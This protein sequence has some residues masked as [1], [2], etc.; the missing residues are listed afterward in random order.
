MA[1][2]KKHCML[3]LFICVLLSI[4]S[5]ATHVY[6]EP[7]RLLSRIKARNVAYPEYGVE[8]GSGWNS[9]LGQKMPSNCVDVMEVSIPKSEF[10][11]DYDFVLDNYSFSKKSAFSGGGKFKGFGF[12]ASVS[13]SGSRESRVNRDFMSVMFTAQFNFGSTQAVPVL[14]PKTILGDAPRRRSEA[15]REAIRYGRAIRL[16]EE[17]RVLLEGQ[18]GLSKFIQTCGDAF[19]IAVHRGV[20]ANVLATLQASTQAAKEEFAASVSA[21]G[22]GGAVGFTASTQ[23][24]SS[25]ENKTVSYQFFQ[26][27]GLEPFFDVSKPEAL[28]PDALGS[29]FNTGRLLEGES[30]FMATVLPYANLLDF[31]GN[32]EAAKVLTIFDRLDEQRALFAFLSDLAAII[33]EIDRAQITGQESEQWLY[34]PVSIQ[35]LE[36]ERDVALTRFQIY[37]LMRVLSAS[38]E[39]CYIDQALCD[40]DTIEVPK[41]ERESLSAQLKYSAAVLAKERD[42]ANARISALVEA[43][44]VQTG[45]S[46]ENLLQRIVTWVDSGDSV[47]DF[48]RGNADDLTLAIDMNGL[49]EGLVSIAAAI[50]NKSMGG[51]SLSPSGSGLVFERPLDPMEGDLIDDLV[52]R[53]GLQQFPDYES[54]IREKLADA[55]NQLGEELKQ[56]QKDLEKLEEQAMGI[57]KAYQLYYE[58]LVNFDSPFSTDCAG[59]PNRRRGNVLLAPV[60]EAQPEQRTLDEVIALLNE[61]KPCETIAL[62]D[63]VSTIYGLAAATPLTKAQ[64]GLDLLVENPDWAAENESDRLS[65]R[66]KT[67]EDHLR[68][69]IYAERLYP[70]RESL[71]NAT[72]AEAYC[73]PNQELLRYSEGLTL[74]IK[75]TWLADP[76]K[77]E[78]P[79]APKPIMIFDTCNAK[80]GTT[81]C[82]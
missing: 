55:A 32:E 46:P 75:E 10:N 39:S 80:P 19:V 24:A 7:N 81:L 20:R 66:S 3:K 37:R 23:K 56:A 29:L 53:F 62:D 12:K 63:W 13:A 77:V 69:K 76:V 82:R 52:E 49:G 16:T 74:V 54:Q 41:K 14:R 25:A 9:F 58:P 2:A 79:K 40:P 50:E 71:C 28:S 18:D 61:G 38:I 65:K 48:L 45:F 70:F 51:V 36:E 68:W 1:R 67:L 30:S 5:I 43:V 57:L 72:I 47:D 6:A 8:V 33:A 22:F 78:P 35:A 31:A 44:A 64:V 34:S 73:I 17:A 59:L 21:K 26:E 42:E 60:G 4:S 27:G 11:I 15:E